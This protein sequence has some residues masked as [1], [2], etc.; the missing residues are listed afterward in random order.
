MNYKKVGNSYKS[1]SVE[2]ASPGKIVLMLFDGAIKFMDMALAGFD[3]ED[4]RRKNETIHNNIQKTQNI[5]SELQS[6]LDKK[7]AEK[8]SQT[9]YDLYTY[10]N[11]LLQEANAKKEKKPIQEVS[12]LLK[13]L[14]EAWAEMLTKAEK[15]GNINISSLSCNA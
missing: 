8:F 5:V 9:M 7:A 1:I 4:T 14:R 12:K 11:K 3:I 6:S 2:T 15:D 10:M 13:E